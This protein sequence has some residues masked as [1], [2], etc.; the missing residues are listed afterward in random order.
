MPKLSKKGNL[1]QRIW[2]HISKSGC[3]GSCTL[4]LWWWG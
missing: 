3:E 4:L 1:H 2:S